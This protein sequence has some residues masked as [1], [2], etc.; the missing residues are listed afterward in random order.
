MRLN[1]SERG[2]T[3][4]TNIN[5][6]D[7]SKRLGALETKI[8]EHIG[9]Y[10][11]NVHHLAA[12]GTSGFESASH[13]K[14]TES[15]AVNRIIL[16]TSSNVDVLTLDAGFYRCDDSSKLTNLPSECIHSGIS[17]IDVT[18]YGGGTPPRKTIK[19]SFGWSTVTWVYHFH[20]VEGNKTANLG[21]IRQKMEYPIFKAADSA[22]GVI[23]TGEPLTLSVENT[24]VISSGA[25]VAAFLSIK[26]KI[27]DK[28]FYSEI[29]Y[30]QI[31]NFNLSQAFQRTDNTVTFTNAIFSLTTTQLILKS[32]MSTI[33]SGAGGTP[34]F[35]VNSDPNTQPTITIYQ[36]DMSLL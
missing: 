22:A 10:G 1:G 16:D 18:N 27:S 33:L 25:G 12:N 34:N 11:D 8:S 32:E 6:G 26:Y 5:I 20:G 29:P 21:W 13:Q 7:I 2:V 3:M 36:M 14:L 28:F 35:S 30:S 15:L 17:L 23:S 19:I 4:N 31:S 9:G 24:G